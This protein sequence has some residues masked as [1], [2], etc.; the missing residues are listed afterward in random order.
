MKT[1]PKMISLTSTHGF[2]AYTCECLDFIQIE[3]VLFTVIE[4]LSKGGFKGSLIGFLEVR[5][6]QGTFILGLIPSITITST[7][8]MMG[9]LGFHAISVKISLER[10]VL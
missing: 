2:V 3:S 8:C 9:A 6:K 4:G 1:N 5:F 7:E 10:S